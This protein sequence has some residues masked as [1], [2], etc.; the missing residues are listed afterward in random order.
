MPTAA[1]DAGR[2]TS[3]RR[4]FMVPRVHRW[5]M[6]LQTNWCKHCDGEFEAH[7]SARTAQ[8]GYCSRECMV[9]NATGGPA[10]VPGHSVGE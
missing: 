7:E 9:A 8:M 10:A 5:D 4:T 1:R 3:V 2:E 6:A